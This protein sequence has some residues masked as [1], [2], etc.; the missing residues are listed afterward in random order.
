MLCARSD[1]CRAASICPRCR[2]EQARQLARRKAPVSVPPT[3]SLTPCCCSRWCDGPMAFG[4][5][6]AVA[7]ND[8]RDSEPPRRHLRRRRRPCRRNPSRMDGASRSVSGLSWRSSP[9][10]SYPW[11]GS[12]CWPKRPSAPRNGPEQYQQEDSI[13][14]L[15]V[16]E[17]KTVANRLSVNVLVYPKDSL[18][19]QKSGVLTTDA[20]VRLYP[21][22]DLGDLQY[23][24]GKAPAQV[25]TTIE[26]HGDPGNWPFDTYTTDEISAWSSPG[27]TRTRYG[28]VWK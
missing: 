28:P 9:Y 20:A 1:R 2:V 25:A 24:K 16:E 3:A 21:A 10:T 27:I 8:G 12:T 6:F 14:Q 22:T 18:F 5:R 4:E 19:N 13:V 15:R 17:L 11:L 7:T 26:A 23:P